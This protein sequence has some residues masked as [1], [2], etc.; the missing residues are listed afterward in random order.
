[1]SQPRVG[2]LVFF[3]YFSLRNQVCSGQ[4][5]PEVGRTVC[6][7]TWDLSLTEKCKFIFEYGV[8]VRLGH[9]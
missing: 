5:Q 3:L 8:G 2:W 6:F 7:H 4:G 1:M 9:C